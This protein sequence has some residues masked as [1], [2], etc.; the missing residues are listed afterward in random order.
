MVSLIRYIQPNIPPIIDIANIQTPTH[1]I[2][3]F[4]PFVISLDYNSPGTAELVL[5]RKTYRVGQSYLGNN[6][7]SI[8]T[9]SMIL[10]KKREARCLKYMRMDGCFVCPMGREGSYVLM[11]GEEIK[12]LADLKLRREAFDIYHMRYEDD[13]NQRSFAFYNETGKIQDHHTGRPAVRE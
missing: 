4:I 11:G 5:N 7:K 8:Y 10:P 9:I 12:P 3:D 13:D 6:E 2:Y 1:H